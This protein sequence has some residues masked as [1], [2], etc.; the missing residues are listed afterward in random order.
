MALLNLFKHLQ[1]NKEE[2][3]VHCYAIN[4]YTSTRY[5]FSPYGFIYKC[6]P[7][8]PQSPAGREGERQKGSGAWP[9]EDVYGIAVYIS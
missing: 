7:L 6:Q 4:N 3:S 5:C 9:G 1:W 2:D 8:L